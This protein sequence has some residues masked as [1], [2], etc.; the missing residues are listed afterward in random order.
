MFLLS[1]K[2]V[3]IWSAL[4]RTQ[5]ASV[6]QV[7]LQQFGYEIKNSFRSSKLINQV[8]GNCKVAPASESRENITILCFHLCNYSKAAFALFA[9]VFTPQLPVTQLSTVSWKTNFGLEVLQE[10][11]TTST[12]LY[13][14]LSTS[15]YQLSQ[16]QQPSAQSYSPSVL[17]QF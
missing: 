5:L 6:S 14:H 7:Y 15:L 1:V 3:C 11:S 12:S 17:Y 10:Y 8:P 9:S 16:L 13:I 2:L 4:P